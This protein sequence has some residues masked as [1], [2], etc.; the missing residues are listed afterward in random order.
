MVGDGIND[1]P[2][3]AAADVGIA[4]GARGRERVIGGGRRRH[5]CQSTRSRF[6]RR[7]HRRAAL[8]PSPCKVLSLAWRF[9]G[10]LWALPH[11]L[12]NP[13]RRSAYTRG[14]RRRRNPKRSAG[15]E[16]W[17][18]TPARL[19][20]R[21]RR[22]RI[23]GRITR[24]SKPALTVCARLRTPSTTRTPNRGRICR[25]SQSHRGQGHR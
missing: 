14:H 24:D 16:P 5:P 7:C 8:A 20:A 15:L 19:D 17:R 1:A 2:A 23:F 3:L 4:M 6:G 11:S 13:S 22:A 25:R 21:G 12:A 10:S 9:P 18:S